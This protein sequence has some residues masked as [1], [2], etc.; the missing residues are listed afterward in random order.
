MIIL[1]IS[2]LA[3]IR[4]LE[5]VIG[6][7]SCLWHVHLHCLVFQKGFSQDFEWLKNEWNN[8]VCRELGVN[9]SEK[10][11][12]VY[13][14]QVE[15]EDLMTSCLEVIKYIMKPNYEIYKNPNIFKIAYSCLKGRRQVNS[16]GVLRKLVQEV[17]KEDAENLEQ[18]IENFTCENCGSNYID[19]KFMKD[20]RLFFND[21]DKEKE[22]Q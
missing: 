19:L 14:K 6:E 11:G 15:K 18:K 12:S 8:V 20:K 21:Y 16:W 17:E 10:F 22:L 2:L 7:N 9:S 3:G 5:V 1:K 13:I 4:S